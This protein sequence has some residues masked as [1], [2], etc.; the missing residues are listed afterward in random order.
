LEAHEAI[1][2]ELCELPNVATKCELGARGTT[3]IAMK[4]RHRK[5]ALRHG[6]ALPSR[7]ADVVTK[8]DHRELVSDDSQS[9]HEFI[10]EA[11]IVEGPD[12]LWEIV[13][14]LWPELLHKIKPPR[15]LMH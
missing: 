10:R 11:E 7:E 9:I 2:S 14:Q 3:G 5:R 4:G 8:Y 13:S 1:V 6:G 15:A 12:E